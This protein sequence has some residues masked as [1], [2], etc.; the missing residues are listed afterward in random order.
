MITQVFKKWQIMRYLHRRIG[1]S[2]GIE[3]RHHQ[4]KKERNLL[5]ICLCAERCIQ[6]NLS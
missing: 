6:E 2:N 5:C 3:Q 1:D 4:S